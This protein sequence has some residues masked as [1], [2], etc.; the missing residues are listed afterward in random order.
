[1][2]N[3]NRY[4]VIVGQYGDHGDL[5]AMNE[6]LCPKKEFLCSLFLQLIYR[7]GRTNLLIR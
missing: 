1:M 4:F 7:Y 3:C 5:L 2:T 6:V